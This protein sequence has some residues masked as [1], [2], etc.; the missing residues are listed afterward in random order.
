MCM[1][2][3]LVFLWTMSLPG[4]HKHKKLSSDLLEPELQIVISC[5]VDARSQPRSTSRVI[6]A[7]NPEPSLQPQILLSLWTRRPDIALKIA[8]FPEDYFC[9]FVCV[10]VFVCTYKLGRLSRHFFMIRRKGSSL[11]VEEVTTIPLF[12]F[13]NF[14]AS[15]AK[16]KPTVSRLYLIFIR[17]KSERSSR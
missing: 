17:D 3:L 14:C 8:W 6:S 16:R 2:V 9:V 15:I 13:P 12:S 10:S 4:T 1:G 5:H 11:P 7:P